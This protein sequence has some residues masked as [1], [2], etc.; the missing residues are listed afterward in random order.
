LTATG[1]QFD[2]VV[3]GGGTAGITAALAA[4]SVGALVALVEREPRLGGDCT[5]Y[6]CVPSKALLEIAKVIEDARRAAAEGIFAA[7]PTIDY[8]QAVARMRRIV[9]EIA[10]D[11]REE[12]FERAGIRSSA[13]RRASARHTSSTSTESASPVRHSSSRPAASRR[14]RRW[15]G[16]SRCR[17]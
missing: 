6:G 10:A 12:R 1:R 16:S 7:A 13:G 15:P 2:V 5:F 11:E 9:E 14:Y 8:A 17:T 4:R 3:I